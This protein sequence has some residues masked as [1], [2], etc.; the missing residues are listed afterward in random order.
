M[1]GYA[2]MAEQLEEAQRELT[3]LRTQVTPPAG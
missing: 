2:A 1:S 3:A